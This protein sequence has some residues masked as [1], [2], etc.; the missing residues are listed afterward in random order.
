MAFYDSV[1]TYML[2]SPARKRSSKSSYNVVQSIGMAGFSSPCPGTELL[3]LQG[4][5]AAFLSRAHKLT[6]SHWLFG[7]ISLLIK[8]C[9][10]CRITR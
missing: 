10:E 9:F 2:K 1:I 8:T 6:I 7:G 5:G 3:M 4:D